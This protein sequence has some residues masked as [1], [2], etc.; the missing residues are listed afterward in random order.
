MGAERVT[1]QHRLRQVHPVLLEEIDHQRDVVAHHL[2]TGASPD[3]R[4][5]ADLAPVDDDDV[6]IAM[7]DVSYGKRDDARSLDF[8][9][10]ALN[11]ALS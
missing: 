6:V 9:E 3:I 5:D 2:D 8:N 7:L 11:R 4:P 1:G 10:S